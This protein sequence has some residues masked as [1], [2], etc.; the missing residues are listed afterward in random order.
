MICVDTEFMVAS[1][2]WKKIS[3]YTE[4]KSLKIK[5]LEDIFLY[6]H[7]VI[8]YD[9]KNFSNFSNFTFLEYSEK[10]LRH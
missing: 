2:S 8:F 4:K 1:D 3:Y 6:K 7:W 10:I 9:P 5:E